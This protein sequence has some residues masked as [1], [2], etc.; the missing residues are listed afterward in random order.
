VQALEVSAHCR[1]SAGAYR[2]MRRG[3][4]DP[5][6]IMP[7]PRQAAVWKSRGGC[8]GNRFR[9]AAIASIGSIA[10]ARPIPTMIM[11]AAAKQ[12]PAEPS[13]PATA[14][15]SPPTRQDLEARLEANSANWHDDRFTG[16]MRTSAYAA[17][18][19]LLSANEERA[20]YRTVDG[21][22]TWARVALTDQ[23]R[24]VRTC[25]SIPKNP[26][27][28]FRG[29]WQTLRRPLPQGMNQRA[30][31]A[32]GSINPAKAATPGRSSYQSPR[33][34]TPDFGKD[35]QA[36]KERLRSACPRGFWFV[37]GKARPGH[38][39]SDSRRATFSLKR[40]GGLFRSDDSGAHL[41]K[42]STP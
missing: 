22:K 37:F 20:F 40:K 12:Y 8:A 41:E 25:A 35:A 31:R 16:P 30:A 10:V 36:G 13:C 29:R 7:Q 32:A 39:T 11:S 15:T 5:K 42:T 6:F 28:S 14:F 38:R 9:R 24:R 33:T 4:G 17:S 27:I 18:S 1:P 3:R 2:R 34:K 21:G 26:S 19:G 23:H